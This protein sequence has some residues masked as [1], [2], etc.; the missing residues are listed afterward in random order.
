MVISLRLNRQNFD[1]WAIFWSD[2]ELFYYQLGQSSGM[3][4]PCWNAIMSNL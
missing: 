2:N 3:W 1:K 4:G